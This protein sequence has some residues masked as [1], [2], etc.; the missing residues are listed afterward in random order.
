MVYVAT[1]PDA[2]AA[3]DDWDRSRA[4][5]TTRSS[6]SRRRPRGLSDPSHCDLD[7]DLDVRCEEAASTFAADSFSGIG[8]VAGRTSNLE[9][10]RASAWARST[11][12][13]CVALDN[14]HRPSLAVSNST[15]KHGSRGSRAP[16]PPPVAQRLAGG[17]PH[18]RGLSW[19]GFSEPSPDRRVNSCRL[20][21]RPASVD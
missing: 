13:S 8:D 12:L 2:D 19:T 10:G 7:V 17:E 3:H 9:D 11:S 20:D 16:S 4:W 1:Y 14:P 21:E 6:G 15:G 5:S 18:R